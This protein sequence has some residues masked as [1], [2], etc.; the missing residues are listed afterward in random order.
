M[1][2]TQIQQFVIISVHKFMT[3]RMYTKKMY[4]EKMNDKKNKK[5]S[6]LI[7]IAINILKETKKNIH[8]QSLPHKILR[9]FYLL[10]FFWFGFLKWKIL[11]WER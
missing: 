9:H 1:E 5:K 3:N 11:W 2:N 4:I 8:P 6:T 10:I 7:I